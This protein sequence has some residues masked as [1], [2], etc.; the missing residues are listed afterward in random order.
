MTNYSSH[1]RE[2]LTFITILMKNAAYYVT[3]PES[4]L[5]LAF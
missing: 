1:F 3:T 2:I 5:K 4:L